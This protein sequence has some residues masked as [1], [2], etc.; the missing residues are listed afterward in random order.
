MP[1][2]LTSG[3]LKGHRL[4]DISSEFISMTVLTS[5]FYSSTLLNVFVYG[6]LFFPRW[7]CNF[8]NSMIHFCHLNG[9]FVDNSQIRRA[10]TIGRARTYKR[11]TIFHNI[12]YA[13]EMRNVR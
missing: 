12:A 4:F 6:A 9:V 10:C 8:K 13:M 3:N 11:L 5:G 7:K 1:Y 2:S